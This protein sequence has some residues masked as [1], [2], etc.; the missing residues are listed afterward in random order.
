[1]K[2]SKTRIIGITGGIA[3]GKSTVSNMILEEGFKLIDSDE[4]AREVVEKDSEGLERI[5]REFGNDIIDKDGTLDREKLGN[6]I[7]NDEGKRN[8]LNNILHPL[9]RKSIIEKIEK[10]RD[11]ENVIFVDVPLLFESKDEIEESGLFFDE[12]WLVYCDKETQMR[13]L[14]ERDDYNPE[15]AIS[16]I[17]AQF[18]I[19]EKKRLADRIIDNSGSIEHSR[20]QVLDFLDEYR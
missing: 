11:S 19:E 3:T 10:A 14:M 1:M 13:R 18:D 9:I 5:V 15:Q 17:D 7:F 2:Q 12:I 4:A 20:E 8:I 16:R 6:I